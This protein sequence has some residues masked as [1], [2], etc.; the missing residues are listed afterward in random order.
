MYVGKT[1]HALGRSLLEHIGDIRR[2]S[3]KS[4]VARHFNEIHMHGIEHITMGIHGGDIDKLL[5]KK[6]LKWIYT[7]DTLWPKGL[8]E[9]R[10]FRV[11]L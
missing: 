8:N 4:S 10:K 5:L 6:E 7:L 2:K 11:L 9:E 3:P 1:K